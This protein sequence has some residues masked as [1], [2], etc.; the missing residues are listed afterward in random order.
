MI[1]ISDLEEVLSLQRERVVQDQ[2]YPRTLL[3]KLTL[4]KDFALIIMGI[5]RCGKSTLLGTFPIFLQKILRI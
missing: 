5:R 2:S 1:K 3:Q 4:S